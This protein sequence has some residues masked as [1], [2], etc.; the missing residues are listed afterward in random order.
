MKKLTGSRVGIDQGD[1]EVF[2]EFATG[3]DM[4]TGEGSR[5]RRKAVSFSEPFRTPPTVQV[6]MSL[7]DI[8]QRA[9][10]RADVTAEN[11][12]RSGCD[13]VF[14]TWGDTRVARVRM[15]WLAIGEVKSEDDWDL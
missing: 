8:D 4:W 1:E 2:S 14:R 9:N 7:W 10:I 13:L 11:V 15:S 5:E 6:A 12:T 3:G